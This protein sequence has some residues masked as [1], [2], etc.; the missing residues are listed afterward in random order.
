LGTAPAPG[1]EPAVTADAAAGGCGRGGTPGGGSGGVAGSLRL[2]D[3]VGGLPRIPLGDPTPL[4]GQQGLLDLMAGSGALDGY[5][6]GAYGP[7]PN[8]PRFVLLVVR[9]KEASSAG[10]IA[11]TMVDAI[12][13]SLGDLSEPQAF[14]R[15]GVRYECANASLGSLCSFQD[16]ATV[17]LG[18]SRDTDLQRLSRLTDEARRG[19]RG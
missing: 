3:Q 9:A 6:L 4:G 14:T 13:N 17:G 2:P 19:V 10:P 18:F 15:N 11:G 16:G 8:D 7:D 1:G 12:R 5:G